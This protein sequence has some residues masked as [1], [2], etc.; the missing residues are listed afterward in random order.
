MALCLGES[1]IEKNGFDPKDQMERYCRW[2][3]EGYM[4]NKARGRGDNLF[5]DQKNALREHF[6]EICGH[7]DWKQQDWRI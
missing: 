6:F 2:Y 3:R 4:S 1:L 7:A 5:L